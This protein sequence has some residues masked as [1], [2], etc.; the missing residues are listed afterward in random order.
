MAGNGEVVV[1]ASKGEAPV[2]ASC[3][4][5]GDTKSADRSQISREAKKSRHSKKELEFKNCRFLL[6]F[7]LKHWQNKNIECSNKHCG[8]GQA[9]VFSLSVF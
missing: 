7:C 4:C 5:Y 1:L 3:C 8:L 9:W 6:I 2:L